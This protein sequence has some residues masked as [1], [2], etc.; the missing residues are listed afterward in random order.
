[1]Y[2]RDGVMLLLTSVSSLPSTLSLSTHTHIHTHTHQLK[3]V[4]NRSMSDSLQHEEQ[5]AAMSETLQEAEEKLRVSVEAQESLRDEYEQHMQDMKQKVVLEL[6]HTCYII[7]SSHIYA[8][9]Q[10]SCDVTD[11]F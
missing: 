11:S 7:P 5:L 4:L 8:H 10:S 9:E 1:M 3:D 2:M 6:E